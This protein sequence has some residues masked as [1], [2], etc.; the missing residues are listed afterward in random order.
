MQTQRPTCYRGFIVRFWKEQAAD[1]KQDVARFT[2]EIPATGQRLGFLS[3]EV[4]LE[5][6]RRE[7]SSAH[8]AG[9]ASSIESESDCQ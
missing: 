7:I 6:L 5:A 4:L 8:A 3:L 1:P 2:L 9:E